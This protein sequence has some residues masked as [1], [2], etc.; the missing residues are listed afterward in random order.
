MHCTSNVRDVF[1]RIIT[2]IGVPLDVF[3]RFYALTPI[4]PQTAVA[5]FPPLDSF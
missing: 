2:N 3:L 1:A 4:L 5:V